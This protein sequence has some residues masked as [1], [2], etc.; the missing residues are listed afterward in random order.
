MLRVSV[1]R[2]I[3]SCRISAR[4]VRRCDR[5]DSRAAAAAPFKNVP[6]FHRASTPG[7]AKPTLC[8]FTVHAGLDRPNPGHS[9]QA[10]RLGC[11]V[12]RQACHGLNHLCRAIQAPFCR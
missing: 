10:R 2:A 3:L 1:V 9:A 8:P 7:L 12:L 5:F 11:V 4:R 6:P